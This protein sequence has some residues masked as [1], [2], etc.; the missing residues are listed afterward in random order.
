MALTEMCFLL[1][2]EDFESSDFFQI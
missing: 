2:R 1:Q